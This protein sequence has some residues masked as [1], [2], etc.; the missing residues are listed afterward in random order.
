MKSQL[1]SPVGRHAA[2]DQD[3]PLIAGPVAGVPA[4][5]NC[6][7]RLEIGAPDRLVCIA[8]LEF[9]SPLGGGDCPHYVAAKPFPEPPQL[10]GKPAAKGT[11]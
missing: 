10:A 8:H 11:G 7:R 9:R 3:H 2:T 1:D 4:C 5:C 6:D